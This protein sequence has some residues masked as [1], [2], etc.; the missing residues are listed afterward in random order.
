[1]SGTVLFESEGHK[2]VLLPVFDQGEAVP[3]NQHVVVHG[4][5]GMI[6]DPGGHKIYTRV[7]S[8]TTSVLKGAELKYIFL[9][10]QDP[11]IVAATNGWLMT[12][13]AVAYT[14]SVWKRFIPHFG[15]D[16]L[17]VDR[18]LGVPDQ[19]MRIELG[20]Q[21]LLIL[22]A[23]FLHSCGNI[24]LYDPVSKILYT[25]DLG[26]SLGQDYD[27][28]TDF[29][30]HLEFM[31]GFHERYMA[32]NAAMRLWANMV[33]GLDIDM[34]APQHGA[35][36]PGKELVNRFIAWAAELRCGIDLMQNV[37]AIPGGK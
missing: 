13:D 37:I 17:V 15:L 12:T 5:E 30:S 20:G 11:D 9:S 6:L 32:S 18:L 25:G 4:K 26:A 21:E 14:P 7:L 16:R 22:P 23:H 10:H 8:D 28:V 27:V 3:A 33:R 34:I 24:Q 29:D 2:N 35:R 31:Q 36:F 19:G 1:M